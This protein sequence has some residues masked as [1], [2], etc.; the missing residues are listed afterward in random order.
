M[1][2][3]LRVGMT[4]LDFTFDNGQSKWPQKVWIFMLNHQSTK[5]MASSSQSL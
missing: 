1:D 5:L 2:E 4:G 3:R